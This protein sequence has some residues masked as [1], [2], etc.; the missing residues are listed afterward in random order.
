MINLC[1][2]KIVFMYVFMVSWDEKKR[3]IYMTVSN[4]GNEY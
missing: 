1:S 4:Q 2:L 3:L